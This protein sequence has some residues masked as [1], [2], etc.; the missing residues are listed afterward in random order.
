M[1][2]GRWHGFPKHAGAAC[3]G[4]LLHFAVMD[5]D[6]DHKAFKIIHVAG[7]HGA[8]VMVTDA[9]PD[10]EVAGELQLPGHELLATDWMRGLDSAA[11]AGCCNHTMLQGRCEGKAFDV[12][13]FKPAPEG[14]AR[15]Q[16][17]A[18]QAED[19][20]MQALGDA[21]PGL[22][23][24]GAAAAQLGAPDAPPAFMGADHCSHHGHGHPEGPP[25]AGPESGPP[26]HGPDCEVLCNGKLAWWKGALPCPGKLTV[27]C[28]MPAAQPQPQPEGRRLL[29]R[30][31]AG[32]TATPGDAA[33]VITGGADGGGFSLEAQCT[34]LY[35][36]RWLGNKCW[37]VSVSS[38]DWGRGSKHMACTDKL[39]LSARHGR[40]G[41]TM[42]A[43]CSGKHLFMLR[44]DAGE[45]L[46]PV[47]HRMG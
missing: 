35:S 1:C 26:P 4:F 41:A 9:A 44:R 13:S 24:W 3:D 39:K 18:R 8:S 40:G 34:G 29:M 36:G 43:F 28:R 5:K 12:K 27:S 32:D 31:Q 25:H 42:G 23:T 17:E 15:Q 6:W 45:A 46:A 14:P 22:F 33:D 7:C 21:R 47:A 30:L 20:A 16:Q 38:V 19:L 11:G 2:D 10:A 37:G